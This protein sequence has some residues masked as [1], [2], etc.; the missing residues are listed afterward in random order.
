MIKI[1]FRTRSL[2]F[3]SMFLCFSVVSFAQEITEENYLK[4]DKELWEQYEV[5][6]GK[7]SE[8]F[9]KYPEKKDS[10]IKVADDIYN[11]VQKNNQELAI[12]FASVPSGLKRLFMTRLGIPKHTLQS[13]LSRL[14]EDMKNSPYGKSILLHINSDQ[15]EKGSQYYDFEAE[16][17]EDEKFNL[18]SLKG[19]NVL[20]L[21]GGFRL[22]G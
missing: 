14:P 2:I 11:V 18:S 9:K 6:M 3:I 5:D 7:I 19:K 22:Y 17:P 12:K 21:Y 1:V 20:L 10:L 16:T 8:T 15:I 13:T 4:L